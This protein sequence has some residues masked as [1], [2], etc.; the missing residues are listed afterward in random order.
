M[1]Q[2][3]HI[4]ISILISK[5]YNFRLDLHPFGWCGDREEIA[6]FELVGNTFLISVTFMKIIIMLKVGFI[7]SQYHY[8]SQNNPNSRSTGIYLLQQKTVK[9]PI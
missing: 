8:N 2:K 5:D 3:T 4:R 7:P 9:N 6:N 1:H